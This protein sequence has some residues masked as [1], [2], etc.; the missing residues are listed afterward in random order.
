MN[1]VD[2]LL[3]DLSASRNAIVAA[4]I[5]LKRPGCDKDAGERHLGLCRAVHDDILDQ[6]RAAREAMA[7][8]RGSSMPGWKPGE[9]AIRAFTILPAHAHL[10]YCREP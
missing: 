8:Q 10:E 4:R 9:P 1:E 3:R 2:R 7:E 5:Y 6:L